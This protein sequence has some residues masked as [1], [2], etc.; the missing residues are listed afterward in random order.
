MKKLSVSPAEGR[1][2]ILSKLLISR[3]E[4]AC[5]SC[6]GDKT[7][8]SLPLSLGFLFSK[9]TGNNGSNLGH[10]IRLL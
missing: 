10:A 3:T 6:R 4:S 2:E 8:I 1:G 9:M 5:S 7:F